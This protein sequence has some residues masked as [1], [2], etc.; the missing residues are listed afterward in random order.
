LYIMIFG[1]FIGGMLGIVAVLAR[2][3]LSRNR[4]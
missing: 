3:M 4:A 2:V 1:A